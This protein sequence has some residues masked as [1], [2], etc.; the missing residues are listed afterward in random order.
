MVAQA[1]AFSAKAI[2]VV[3]ISN[4]VKGISSNSLVIKVI[5]S[6]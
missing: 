1:P 4:L 3:L 2:K 5:Q 6:S